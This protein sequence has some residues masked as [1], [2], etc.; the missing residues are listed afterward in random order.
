MNLLVHHISHA[1]PL[2]SCLPARTDTGTP[3]YATTCLRSMHLRRER[4]R[5]T[6]D[7]ERGRERL[8]RQQDL[9]LDICSGFY[10]SLFSKV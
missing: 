7:R 1:H 8:K 4:S 2:T 6:K 9:K 3:R 5:S 10:A